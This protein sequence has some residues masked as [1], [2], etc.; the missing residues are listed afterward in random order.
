MLKAEASFLSLVYQAEQNAPLSAAWIGLIELSQQ[1]PAAGAQKRFGRLPCDS[2][3]H[4]ITP[5]GFPEA[6]RN[7]SN[8]S[9]S[10]F[11]PGNSESI[12]QIDYR[13]TPLQTRTRRGLALV[14]V[15]RARARNVNK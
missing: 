4:E 3:V 12:K 2:E 9:R 13:A 5:S 1:T 6:R 14:Y 15:S 10:W 8:D 7:G 11:L